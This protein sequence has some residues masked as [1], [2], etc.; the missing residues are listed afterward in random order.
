MAEHFDVK[1]ATGG[2]I[3]L[4]DGK[5][6]SD[7]QLLLIQGEHREVVRVRHDH[8][9]IR[10]LPSAK[11]EQAIIAERDARWRE[12]SRPTRQRD[13]IANRLRKLAGQF[14]KPM[15]YEPAWQFVEAPKAAQVIHPSEFTAAQEAP[16]PGRISPSTP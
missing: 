2:I 12:R 7:P 8:E 6:Y 3:Q 1:I 13:G 11:G 4:R 14:T 5:R 16:E 9:Q 10:V 15:E